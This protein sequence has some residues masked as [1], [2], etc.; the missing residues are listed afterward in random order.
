MPQTP[1]PS[2]FS[3]MPQG[4][5]QTSQQGQQPPSFTPKQPH[6]TTDYLQPNTPNM[7]T[8]D[9]LPLAPL[10]DKQPTIS[11]NSLA[12]PTPSLML[13][14]P[15]FFDPTQQS[16]WA[17]STDETYGSGHGQHMN[18]RNMEL[19]SDFHDLLTGLY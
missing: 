2:V 17:M 10:A 4:Q 12:T 18:W 5:T 13:M 8:L 3:R 11:G 15:L 7:S 1:L 16:S 14:D 6:V 9:Y 19:P